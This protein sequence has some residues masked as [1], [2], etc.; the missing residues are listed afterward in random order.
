MTIA[1]SMR[2]Y[3]KFASVRLCVYACEYATHTVR[4]FVRVCV[5]VTM[6]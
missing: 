6:G 3:V 2:G 5:L 1:S 4:V